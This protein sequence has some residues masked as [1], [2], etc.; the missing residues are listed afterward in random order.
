VTATKPSQKVYDYAA[1]PGALAPR[2]AARFFDLAHVWTLPCEWRQTIIFGGKRTLQPE[3]ENYE[4][5]LQAFT[6]TKEFSHFRKSWENINP[7]TELDMMRW[8]LNTQYIMEASLDHPNR[9]WT[10]S[11]FVFV[12]A[13]MKPAAKEGGA[14]ERPN[15]EDTIVEWLK[16][17]P[18]PGS[19]LVSCGAPYG[20]A[21]DEAFRMLLEPRGFTVETFGHAAPDLPLEVFMREVAGCVHR[22]RRSR[23]A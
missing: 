9:W 21:I 12:D 14:P 22:I 8:G 4:H 10:G 18:T 13:P 16:S 15:T 2:A 3:K 1:W 7:Q 20:M 5:C 23:K 17:N 6:G 11:N 19:M